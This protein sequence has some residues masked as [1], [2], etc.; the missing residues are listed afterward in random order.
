VDELDVV[1][2][3]EESEEDDVLEELELAESEDEVLERL[4]LR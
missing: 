3:L 1:E 4:S 2:E